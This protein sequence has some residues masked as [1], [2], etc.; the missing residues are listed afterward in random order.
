MPHVKNAADAV[1]VRQHS[2]ICCSYRPHLATVEQ[3]RAHHGPAHPVLF[4]QRYIASLPKTGLRARKCK[5]RQT[6]PASNLFG[7]LAVYGE[8]LADVLEFVN[9]LR[10]LAIEHSVLV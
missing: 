2:F 8:H 1:I 7:T 5:A 9:I 4:T 3:N 10:G 6:N